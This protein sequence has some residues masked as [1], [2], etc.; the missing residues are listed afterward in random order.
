VKPLT[1]NGA[2]PAGTDVAWSAVSVRAIG[3]RHRPITAQGVAVTFVVHASRGE[4]AAATVRLSVA[5]A[6]AKGRSL[7]AE[8]WQ[9]FITGPDGVRYDPA[10][11][12]KLLSRHPALRPNSD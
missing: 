10:E 12:D 9:V 3:A 8:G 1:P 7:L 5:V 2:V 6:I 11:F 4:Q